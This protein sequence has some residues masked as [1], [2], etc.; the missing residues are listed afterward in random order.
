[1]TDVGSHRSVEESPFDVRPIGS[2]RQ[3]SPEKPSELPPAAVTTCFDR[4]R[5]IAGRSGAS[6]SLIVEQTAR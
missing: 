1:V 6:W 2:S 5:P 3:G 4:N